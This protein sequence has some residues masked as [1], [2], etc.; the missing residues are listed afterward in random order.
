MVR[1]GK[2]CTI[3]ASNDHLACPFIHTVHFPASAFSWLQSEPADVVADTYQVQ[4][5]PWKRR[6]RCKTCGSNVTSENSKT[7][8][9]SIWGATLDRDSNGRI[10]GW[11]ALKPTSHM[12]YGTRMVDVA[13]DLGKWEGYEN[14]SQRLD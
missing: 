5:K 14:Q 8:R 10:I 1:V 9:W 13:D 7:Q 2:D 11:E 12:F 3:A 6:W 4:S